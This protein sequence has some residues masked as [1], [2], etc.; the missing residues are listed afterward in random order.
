MTDNGERS[1]DEGSLRV[2]DNMELT[3]EGTPYKATGE[4]S[5]QL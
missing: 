4:A 5:V 2:S 3:D 1:P